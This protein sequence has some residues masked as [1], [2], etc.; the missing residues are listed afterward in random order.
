MSKISLHEYTPRFNNLTLMEIDS[1][2]KEIAST[3]KL[4]LLT[5]QIMDAS[6]AYI[7]VRG[8]ID[9]E[10]ASGH[11]FSVNGKQFS[12]SSPIEHAAI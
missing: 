4:L 6:A 9:P 11:R 1:Y 10:S 5:G 2:Y 3:R 8:S 12:L 7:L